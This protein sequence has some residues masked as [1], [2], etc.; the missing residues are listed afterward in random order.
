MIILNIITFLGALALMLYYS[1]LLTLIAI[2]L[3]VVPVIA[4]MIFGGKMAKAKKLVSDQNEV[5]TAT[6]KDTLSG[7][8]VIKS[9]KV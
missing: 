7:F 4:S 5:Y 6:L 8:S 3:A 9:F 2:G 1:P